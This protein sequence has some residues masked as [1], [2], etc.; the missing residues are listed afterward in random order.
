MNVDKLQKKQYLDAV[1]Q[2]EQLIIKIIL[3]IAFTTGAFIL[4]FFEFWIGSP[5]LQTIMC[6]ILYLGCFSD[7]NHGIISIFSRSPTI[8]GFLAVSLSAAFIHTLWST[9]SFNP[10]TNPNHFTW[11]VFLS[12]TI[13]YILKCCYIHLFIKNLTFIQ[14]ESLNSVQIVDADLKKR[15]IS[16]VCM[17]TPLEEF[18]EI[19]ER[20]YSGDYVKNQGFPFVQIALGLC[21]LFSIIT[22]FF[23]GTEAMFA[24]LS[25][26]TCISVCFSGEVSFILPYILAQKKLKKQGSILFGTYS[27]I[28]L[29]YVNTLLVE[30]TDLFSSDSVKIED[31]TFPDK[32]QMAHA[33]E[34]AA[35]LLQEINSPLAKNIYEMCS[36]DKSKMP[37]ISSLRS[38][39]NY[40]LIGLINSDEVHFGNRN[41]L[42][43]Y[44]ISPLPQE[45]E[46]EATAR[47]KSI[48]YLAING[49]VALILTAT[50]A[51]NIH[52]KDSISDTNDFNLI[53]ESLDFNIN[54]NLIS[55][56]YNIP[57]INIM[58]T[59]SDETKL[60]YS[61]HRKAEKSKPDPIMLS[62]QRTIGVL[63][64]II[65]A[66]K[67][68]RAV[69]N[70]AFIKKLGVYTGIILTGIAMIFVPNLVSSLW[71]LLYDLLWTVAAIAVSADKY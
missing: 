33:L 55:K 22:L 17:V 59:D 30:D 71:I 46:A 5:L 56:H 49:K 2:Q 69:S 6:I 31:I 47:G 68:Y 15:Y 21:A 11:M 7:L 45:K 53:V 4:S 3:C 8:G 12:F 28:K 34:Y 41:L 14:K 58:V 38:I 62:T 32:P 64:S 1:R 43:S 10:K 66:K 37:H 51:P 35:V 20:I 67:L 48:M 26:L 40:G 39:Q 23:Q 42:L 36:F 24:S 65:I 57:N 9:I 44:S 60:L 16:R 61:V 19:S 70:S 63:P 18:P 54:E 29:K 25:A 52:L 13:L 50:Y 27:V